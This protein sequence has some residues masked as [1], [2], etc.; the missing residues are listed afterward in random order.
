MSIEYDRYILTQTN[1][2]IFNF[3]NISFN[4]LINLFGNYLSYNE[5]IKYSNEELIDLD[6]A[7]KIFEDKHIITV[8]FNKEY[9]KDIEFKNY[10]TELIFNLEQMNDDE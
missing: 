3:K 6:I 10:G 7:S 8:W 1:F 2:K 4:T 9:I 5:L